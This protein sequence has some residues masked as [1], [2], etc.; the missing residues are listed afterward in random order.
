MLRASSRL[1][2]DR[3]GAVE[4]QPFI[5][6]A[7]GTYDLNLNR[8]LREL[9]S[10]GVTAKNSIAG[11]SRDVML[12]CRFLHESRGGKSIWGCDGE[13]LRAYKRVR[14]RSGPDSVSVG[15]WNRGIAALDKWVAWSTYEGLLERMPFRYVDKTVMT[16]EGPRTVT[17]NSEYV[18]DP[19]D[20][21]A[22]FVSFEDYLLW[23]DVGLRG[24]L[25]EGGRDRSWR[26]RNGERNAM[27]ADVVVHTG[28]RLGE[29][30]SLLV[31]EIPPLVLGRRVTGDVHL[32]KAVTKRNKAR[33]VFMTTRTLRSLHHYIEIERDE[34]VTRRLASGGYARADDVVLVRRT[35]RHALTVA[36]GRGWAYSKID[37]EGRRR[38][39]LM[40]ADGFPGAPL[41][42][43]L[44]EDGQPLQTSTWQSA[45]RRANQR[46]AKFG[47]DIEIHPHTLR[48]VYAVHM[49]GLLLRQTVRALGRR[50]DRRLTRAELKRLLVGNP[51]RKLQQLLGHARESTVY[52]YLDVLDEAQEVVLAAMT[53]W[54]AQAAVLERVEVAA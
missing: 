17:V 50:D 15:T 3:A 46:C 35:G 39:A 20:Q 37:P 49:L 4:G 53:E 7:D 14:L 12:F 27:F 52:A 43:W 13:D 16:P 6:A 36:A 41:W 31:P 21:P 5:L 10:W 24:E 33:T 40:D 26:G 32:S 48:H 30:S 38:L 1:V 51:M 34:L 18:E 8:F 47:I 11:Y 22:R 45:F 25:P 42:L 44:G 29:A 19:E 2:L 28:M 23:R 54:D 9:G